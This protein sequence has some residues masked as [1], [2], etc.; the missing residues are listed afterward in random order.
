MTFLALHERNLCCY[1]WL[2]VI[3][4]LVTRPQPARRARCGASSQD[5]P[6][7]ADRARS[8]PSI[9]DPPDRRVGRAYE[10]RPAMLVLEEEKTMLK[11]FAI[12]APGFL[13]LLG[14]DR[15]RR[16]EPAAT[17]VAQIL[18]QHDRA[19]IRDL[20]AYLGRNPRAEDRD[21][22]YAAL[23]NKSIEH[24][25]FAET[26]E[27]ARRYLKNDPDGPGQGARPDHHDDG[28][29]PGR[30]VRSGPRARTRS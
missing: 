24:D 10:S 6:M 3:R 18:D 1:Q 15:A 22:A 4:N 26:E 19:L 8:A 27:A 16:Q 23:F 13:A 9:R 29:S 20:G 30:P 14:R 11:P 7:P 2:E 5:V 12:L 17:S 21:Q 28:P 25:W